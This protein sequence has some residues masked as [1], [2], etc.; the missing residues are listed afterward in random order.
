MRGA[1]VGVAAALAVSGCGG[2]GP[3]GAPGGPIRVVAA[4]S[5]WG[6]IASQLGG[7]HVTVTS[8][9]SDP[10]ADPHSY[11]PTPADAR[12]LAEARMAIVNGVG[13]DA[14]ASKLLSASPAG[15]R[16]VVSVGDL[17]GVRPGGNPHRWYS[18]P[19]VERTIAAIS[20]GYRRLDPPNAAYYAAARRRFDTVGLARYHR[21]V[22]Q[23]RQRYRGTPVGASESIFAPLAQ[24]LG[25]RLITPAGFLAAISEGTDP[26]A[27]D[28]LTIGRQMR[29][30]AIAVWV[31]NDQNTTPDV[32]RLN[33]AAR[34]AGI[35]TA[36]VTETPLP[37]NASFQ[38]WQVR[39]L[40]ALRRALAR[41]TGR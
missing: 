16:V 28:K 34:R 1:L 22:A 27:A 24:A 17:V 31:Y 41:A 8:I 33:A 20:A 13:Y 12:A 6:S 39:Q 5:F 30:R 25:L 19:D 10:A 4:E 14:W 40:E 37:R 9:V 29:D 23:I 36:T 32:Q 3:A 38:S 18:P 21:V 11:E 15:D 35:Q 2:A 7:S 26:T